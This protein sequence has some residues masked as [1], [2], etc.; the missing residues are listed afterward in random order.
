MDAVSSWF[1]PLTNRE[2]LTILGACAI[3]IVV[4]TTLWWLPIR[5]R[6]RA[7]AS[8]QG[9]EIAKVEALSSYRRLWDTVYRV[10]VRDQVGRVRLALVTLVGFELFPT[11]LD[12]EWE[13]SGAPST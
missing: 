13:E 2:V 9:Y 11:R 4:G 6:L 1:P 8:A 5:R 3:A 7:W 10:T 12:I